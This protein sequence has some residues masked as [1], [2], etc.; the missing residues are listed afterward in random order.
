MTL[1]RHRVMSVVGE[2]AAGC[3]AAVMSSWSRWPPAEH[4]GAPVIGV[5][6]VWPSAMQSRPR[7]ANVI[8]VVVGPAPLPPGGTDRDNE[9]G[10]PTTPAAPRSARL[11]RSSSVD[12]STFTGDAVE[13]APVAKGRDDDT[14]WMDEAAADVVVIWLIWRHRDA[15]E[16]ST[17]SSWWRWRWRFDISFSSCNFSSSKL[18]VSYIC[19]TL[20]LTQHPQRSVQFSFSLKIHA[21]QIREYLVTFWEVFKIC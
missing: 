1:W 7:L 16:S 21:F 5:K 9:L 3:K 8:G 14:D 4:E 2:R 6:P 15:C 12:R 17:N 10:L 20:E 19:T 18:S 11:E 13:A